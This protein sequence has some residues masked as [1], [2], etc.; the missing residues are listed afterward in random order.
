MITTHLVQSECLHNIKLAD[1]FLFLMIVQ[2]RAEANFIL[3]TRVLSLSR[4]ER[5]LFI[6]LK[7]NK[8]ILHTRLEPTVRASSDVVNIALCLHHCP[9]NVHKIMFWVTRC[10]SQRKAVRILYT[11]VPWVHVCRPGTCMPCSLVRSCT[12]YIICTP[13]HTI[14]SS[15]CLLLTQMTGSGAKRCKA[16]QSFAT[17]LQMGLQMGLQLELLCGTVADKLPHQR[18]HPWLHST[19]GLHK[20]SRA[21]KQSK[22]GPET[23]QM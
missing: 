1:R 5:S 8:K 3:H 4:Q 12:V 9:H 20:F 13:I 22:C 2:Y 7:K 21:L 6:C 17:S 15:C 19:A 10:I 23:K 11:I 16:A 18:L 14:D